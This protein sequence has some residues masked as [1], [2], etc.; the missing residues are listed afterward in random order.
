MVLRRPQ[1]R[2]NEARGDVTG[3]VVPWQA[4]R[5]APVDWHA[6]ALEIAGEVVTHRRR[7]GDVNVEVDEVV[8]EAVEEYGN[9]RAKKIAAPLD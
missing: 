4:R 3:E 6:V 5:L 7:L 8:G 9:P 1:V 2:P